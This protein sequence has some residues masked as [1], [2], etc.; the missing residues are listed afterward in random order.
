MGGLRTLIPNAFLSDPDTVQ[1]GNGRR[2]YNTRTGEAYEHI[3][4]CPSD[5]ANNGARG[6]SLDGVRTLA[7]A[8][9]PDRPAR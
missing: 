6:D 2:A 5:L 8:P 1:D 7:R 9:R 3:Q 4:V